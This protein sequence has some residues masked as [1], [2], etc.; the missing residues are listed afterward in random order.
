MS[1]E[2]RKNLW[3][4]CTITGSLL[5][6]KASFMLSGKVS[7]ILP[8]IEHAS[9]FSTSYLP[10]NLDKPRFAVDDLNFLILVEM[11]WTVV[12]GGSKNIDLRSR[13][14]TFSLKCFFKRQ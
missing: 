11:V 12:R 7:K 9:I 3:Q 14:S 1:D 8:R 10:N 6:V 13:N 5:R 2:V 4:Y